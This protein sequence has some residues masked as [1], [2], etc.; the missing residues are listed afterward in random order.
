[1]TRTGRSAAVT[2]LFDRLSAVYDTPAVQSVVYRP[3]QDE[4]IRELR[5]RGSSRVADVGCGT[6][7]LAA[8]VRT[9]C[10]PRLVFGFDASEGMLAQARSRSTRVTWA[11]ARSEALPVPDGSLDAVVSSHAFHFFDQPAALA[12]FRRVLAPGGVLVVVVVNPRTSVG[13]RV[14][15][16]GTAGAGLF[17]N[18]QMMRRLVLDA[19]FA[20]VVQHRVHRFALGA[21][22]PDVVTIAT[23]R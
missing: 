5:R 15:S 9:E 18:Q 11:R 6:G 22:S 19:G 16:L 2:R 14:V 10:E 3:P 13:S 21:L 20:E 17:P 23:H 1:M 7:I 8:R 12:E 4:I